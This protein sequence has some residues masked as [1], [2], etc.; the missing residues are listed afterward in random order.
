VTR[1]LSVLFGFIVLVGCATREPA[2]LRYGVQDA[3]E[4]KRLLWPPEP[5]VPR[6]MYAGQLLGEANFRSAGARAAEGLMGVLRAI[7]GVIVGEAKPIELA[8]PQSGAVDPAG[9]I[10]VT[11]ASRQAVFV[12]DPVAGKLDL[13][14]K[15]EGLANFST[16]VALAVGKDLVYVTD[17]ELGIVARLDPTGTPQ[18]ALGR[19]LLKRPTGLALDAER[20]ELYVSDTAAHEVKVLDLAGNLKRVLGRRG[21]GEGEFNYP[22]HLAFAEGELYVTD[23][24]N[25]RIQVLDGASGSMRRS[26]GTRG[27]YVGNLVRPKGIALDSERNV[28]VVESYYDHL[29]VFDRHGRF[30]MGIGGLGAESGKFYL[31]AGVWT[32]HLNRVFVA[33]MFNGR[34][35]LFQHL[36]GGADGEQ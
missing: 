8:R 27:L 4:G 23:T 16:P 20:G 36:G 21:E 14:E 3:P 6:Y 34:V 11:D 29:L 35:V 2:V 10:Y 33:D 28:Y 26:F 24:M 18:R 12:F 7:A 31:P 13:W 19:G 9:R 5:E 17:A 25:S 30:L 22:T 32:D 15:A 1:L